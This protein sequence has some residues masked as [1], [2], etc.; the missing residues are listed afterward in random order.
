VWSGERIREWQNEWL[1]NERVVGPGFQVGYYALRILY[2]K[3][4][5]SV[6]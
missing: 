5:R 3:S 1:V 4:L 6:K 2:T